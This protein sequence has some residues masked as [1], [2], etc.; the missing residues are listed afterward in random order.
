MI[1]KSL[2][3]RIVKVGNLTWISPNGELNT[4]GDGS[5]EAIRISTTNNFSE[6]KL[7]FNPSVHFG[8]S[9]TNGSLIVEEGSIHVF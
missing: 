2:L 6:L 8:E 9:Y 5:G 1:T 4:Y 7:L 3:G